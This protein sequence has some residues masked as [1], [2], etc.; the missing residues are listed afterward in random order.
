M[1]QAY[2]YSTSYGLPY[3]VGSKTVFGRRNDGRA[4]GF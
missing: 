4:V 3:R 2:H 1:T